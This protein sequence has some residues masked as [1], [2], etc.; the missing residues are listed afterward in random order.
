[1]QLYQ[2]TY[3][4]PF[5]AITLESDGISI[6][7]LYFTT[8][9]DDRKIYLDKTV[10]PII[11]AMSWLDLYFS[12]HHP[13]ISSVPLNPSG[14]SFQKEV[15]DR[16]CRIPYGETVTYGEIASEIAA[17]RGLSKMS[18]QAVGQAVGA[19]PISIIIPC[20][21]VIGSNG[22]LTGFS[23]GL[24]CKKWLLIHEYQYKKQD[25]T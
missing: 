9:H 25:N 11:C 5:G 20:H 22:K 21:R 17:K 4:S 6:T 10:P 2:A 15:W 8:H 24:E 7:G 19:N 23:G 12:G 3:A 13:A 14:T 1:M 16:L 18:A